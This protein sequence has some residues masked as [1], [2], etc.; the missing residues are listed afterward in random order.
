MTEGETMRRVFMHLAC[1]IAL[2]GLITCFSATAEAHPRRGSV[3]WSVLLCTFQDSQTPP[4]DPVYYS[5]MFFNPGTSGM[6]DYWSAISHGG[7]NF[8]GSE[9]KGWYR[10]SF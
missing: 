4:H 1:C 7:I 5:N 2:G 8:Q 10:E 9:V 6:A 3:K